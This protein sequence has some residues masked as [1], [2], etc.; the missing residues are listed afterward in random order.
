M[1]RERERGMR[2]RVGGGQVFN[3]RP[4]R[5]GSGSEYRASDE[6]SRGRNRQWQK[7]TCESFRLYEKLSEGLRSV[8]SG[9]VALCEFGTTQPLRDARWVL[10]PSVRH[11]S[12]DG[13]LIKR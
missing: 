5:S 7:R 3:K 13:Y 8:R 10:S 11:V 2:T 12:S 4:V 6:D 9:V 1:G